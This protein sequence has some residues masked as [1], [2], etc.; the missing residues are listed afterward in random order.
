MIIKWNLKVNW[1]SFTHLSSVYLEAMN[2]KVRSGG[3]L[4]IFALN[5][6]L[7]LLL[8]LSTHIEADE[9][10][11]NNLTAHGL[12]KE[13]LVSSM[14]EIKARNTTVWSLNGRIPTIGFYRALH[15]YLKQHF[16][17]TKIAI[18]KLYCGIDSHL[19]EKGS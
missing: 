15:C 9:S 1:I 5:N 10:Y 3:K 6:M 19:K 4:S 18:G 8:L 13:S 11:P 17:T 12:T 2:Q 16:K 7:I 14:S